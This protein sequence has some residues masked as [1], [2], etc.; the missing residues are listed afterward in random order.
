M[1]KI[2]NRILNLIS[3]YTAKEISEKEYFELL[4]WI[5]ES[6]ENEVIFKE[7]VLFYKNQDKLLLQ[8][9]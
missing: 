7:Y 4:Q 9:N 2:D 1:S 5:N 8:I 3:N 6:K